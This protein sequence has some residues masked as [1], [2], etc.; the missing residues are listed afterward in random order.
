M[1]SVTQPGQ[2]N[3]LPPAGPPYWRSLEELADTPEFRQFLE[4]EFPSALP[5][6]MTAPSRR[7]FLQLMGASFALAGLTGCRW[8]V[9]KLAPYANRPEGRTPGVPVSYATALER[10]G[11]GL[12]VLATCYDGRPIKLEGNREHPY[13]WGGAD[14]QTQAQILSLYDPDRSYTPFKVTGA[15]QTESTWEDF[16]AF[17]SEHWAALRS[18]GGAGLAVLCEATQSPTVVRLRRE[19][20]AD[21]AAAAVVQL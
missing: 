17:A 7:R 16:D 10:A 19:L 8:P 3:A 5:A 11:V 12:G 20:A 2:S 15:D 6:A 14:A 21:P 18:A 1:P 9:E 13:S 4:A